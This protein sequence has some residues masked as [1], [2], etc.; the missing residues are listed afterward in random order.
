MGHNWALF[1]VAIWQL[2][3]VAVMGDKLVE[4]LLLVEQILCSL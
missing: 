4:L 1:V 3:L 2:K